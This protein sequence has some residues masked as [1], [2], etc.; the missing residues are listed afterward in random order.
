MDGQ[1]KKVAADTSL[2]GHEIG[3]PDMLHAQASDSQRRVAGKMEN[4]FERFFLL[5]V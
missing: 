5:V 4:Q 2:A 1:T 3:E